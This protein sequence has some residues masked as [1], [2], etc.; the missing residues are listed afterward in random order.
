MAFD[1]STAGNI[2]LFNV[3]MP[4]DQVTF[5]LNPKSFQVVKGQASTARPMT[6]GTS[7]ASPSSAPSGYTSMYRGTAPTQVTFTALLSD[8]ATGI[9][10]EIADATVVGGGIKARCDLLLAWT[11]PGGGSLL[12]KAVSAAAAALGFKFQATA[13]P[14]LLTLQWGD[15]A[16][17]FL[18]QGYLSGVT[19]DYRRFDGAGNPI[20]AEV[21]CT[22]TEAPNFL[23]SLLTNP[24]SGGV[25]GWRSHV[26]TEGDSL[27]VL[28]ADAYGRPQAWR[29]IA[30]ANGIDDPLRLR[31]G[32]RLALPPP[33]EV[34]R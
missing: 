18:M 24:T 30:A 14:T 6:A 20:R 9:G 11:Q 25:P 4:L 34:G 28:A 19:I 3:M 32:R 13:R 17:G 2:K 15:P 23:L 10:D 26:L 33:A 5:D 16:R 12:G 8:D 29:Q 31:P 22:L 1:V 21:K 7:G 27:P